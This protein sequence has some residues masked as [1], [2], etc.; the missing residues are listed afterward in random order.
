ML[1]LRHPVSLLIITL[2]VLLG[3][4]LAIKDVLIVEGV[5]TTCGS[6]ILEGFV[7]PF[8]ATAVQKLLDAGAVVLGKTNTDEFAMGSS[9][10]NSAY[11][12]TRNPWDLS[13]VPGGS[14]GGSAAAV[15][16]APPSVPRLMSRPSRQRNG[17]ID[18]ITRPD[19][20]DS[21]SAAPTTCPLSLMSKA[22]DEDPP[23]VPRY[24]TV[25]SSQRK[26]R[27]PGVA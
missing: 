26:A 24:V 14:S 20:L 16:S 27:G 5:P 17:F 10:E 2:L 12:T 22:R 25:P 15:A 23:N 18:V 7:P 8:T 13:R 11:Q 19:R 4:P 1:K 21:I 9:T 6:H 3:V